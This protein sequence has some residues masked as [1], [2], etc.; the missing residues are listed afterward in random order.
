MN[1]ILEGVRSPHLPLPRAERK[2][3][4]L[5]LSG[6]GYRAALF[7]LGATRRLNELGVLSKVDTFTSVS[8]GS[9]F[10][11][12]LA[13]YAV[14][15]PDAWSKPGQP[16]PDYDDEVAAPMRKLAQHNIRTLSVLRRLLPWN[17]L[18]RD[19]QIDALAERLAAGPTGRA[20]LGDLP[21][22]P[23]F[24]FC[25]SEMQFRAQWTFDSG[26]RRFGSDPPGHAQFGE[27]WTIAR[28]AASSSCL[29]GVFSPMSISDALTG[30]DYEGDD[31]AAL[32]RTLSLS[33]GGMYDNLG[34]EPVWQDHLTVLVSDAGPSFRPD[35]GLGRIWNALRF[36]IILLEQATDVRKR[37]L[38]ANFLTGLLDGAYW[39]VA[40]AAEDYPE[41]STPGYSKPFVRN[42]IAPIRIDLDVF[43]EGE[44]AVLENH[45]YLMADTAI[46]SHASQL[47]PEAAPP[48]PPFPEWMDERR[49][50]E[51]LRES[52]KTKLFARGG[53]RR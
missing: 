14:R 18:K 21:D 30:G 29:P 8:G 49:A 36:A 45:G 44:R 53:L 2:G 31:A 43:S 11:S 26:P 20:R 37:W 46:R 50:A 32:A 13:A 27:R 34:L 42:S 35:P 38:I 10:A 19:V 52:A 40:G 39:G 3:I 16:L 17:W 28:A 41:P 47:A 48:R 6:G 9:I 15:H 33:D 23:R 12:L 51:A 25:A 5:C 24:V 7:H 22:H 4:A 1:E